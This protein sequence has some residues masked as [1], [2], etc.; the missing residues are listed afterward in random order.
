[1]LFLYFLE[2]ILCGL[3]R[4]GLGMVESATGLL[5]GLLELVLLAPGARWDLR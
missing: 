3:Y 1:M 4:S 2:N 5:T